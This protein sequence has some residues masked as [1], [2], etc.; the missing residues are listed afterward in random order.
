[1]FARLSNPSGD[2]EVW[3]QSVIQSEP[4]YVRDAEAELALIAYVESLKAPNRTSPSQEEID[5]LRQ[6]YETKK[7]ADDRFVKMLEDKIASMSAEYSRQAEINMQLRREAE[8]L[9][10]A[11]KFYISN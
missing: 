1:V 10:N 7:S 8:A 11:L 2:I 4:S 9:K 5:S 3:C 6:L